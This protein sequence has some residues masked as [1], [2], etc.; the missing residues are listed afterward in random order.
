[1]VPVEERGLGRRCGRNI[2]L[3][4]LNMLRTSCANSWNPGS[5]G[6]AEG[7]VE[8]DV[9][10]EGGVEGEGGEGCGG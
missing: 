2:D 7:G 8:G 4:A 1:M 9:G 6:G 10:R 3:I 5:G